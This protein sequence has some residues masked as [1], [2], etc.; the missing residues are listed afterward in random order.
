[1]P[2]STPTP[3]PCGGSLPGGEPNIGPPDGGFASIACGDFIIVNL[4]ASPITVNP[5]V[6]H[7]GYDLVYYERENPVGSSEVM[8]DWVIVEIGSSPSGPWYPV[9][10]WYDNVVDTNTNVGQSIYGSGEQDNKSIPFSVLY[11]SSPY[12]TGIAIDV[13]TLA[14][15]P[16]IY[17]WVR[18]RSPLG[19]DNDPAEVDSIQVLP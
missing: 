2:T 9:F 17:T 15:P 4:G 16:G 13:D 18:I 7:A 6:P 14:P 5:S 3:I 8:L 19:G 10:N 12:R 11:G 1:M